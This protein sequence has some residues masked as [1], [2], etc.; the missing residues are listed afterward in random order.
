MP[1][2]ASRHA[3]AIPPFPTGGKLLYRLRKSK[4]YYRD[5]REVSAV[6][7]L[8]VSLMPSSSLMPRDRNLCPMVK[9][10]GLGLGPQG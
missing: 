8:W 7:V 10:Q 2:H 1:S 9:L 5:N 3:F 6:G 4:R